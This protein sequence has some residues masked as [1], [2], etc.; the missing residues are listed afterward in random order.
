VSGQFIYPRLDASA[1]RQLLSDRVGLDLLELRELASTSHP[2]AAPAPTGGHPVDEKLLLELQTEVRNVASDSGFPKR[3]KRG[4]EQAFDRPCGSALFGKM[5][6]VT[7]DAADEGVWTFLT[8]VLLPEIGPWRFPDQ[9]ENRMLGRPRNVLRRLWWRA[10]AFGGDLDFA[11]TGCKPL[12][13]DEFVQI[14]E[15][16]SLG[17]NPRVASAIRDA[18]WRAES[19]GSTVSRS[20][21]MRQ[22]TRRVRATRSHIALDSLTD[23]QLDELLD[24]AAAESARALGADPPR[25]QSAK[26]GAA[27]ANPFTV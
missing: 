18:L 24:G 19:N 5:G 13:E 8:L 21:L 4:K 14:M 22:L 10:W 9:D 12:G 1:A 26:D 27:G 15:R 20:E 17:G 16:P 3:L 25:K 7:A 6:I 11:P 23:P 2:E